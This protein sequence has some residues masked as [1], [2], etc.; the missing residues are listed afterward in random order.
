MILSFSK[1]ADNL[2]VAAEKAAVLEFYFMNAYYGLS[3]SG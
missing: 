3:I 1:E 2:P